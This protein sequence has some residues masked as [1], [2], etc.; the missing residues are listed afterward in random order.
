MNIFKHRPHYRTQKKPQKIQGNLN[1]IKNLLGPQRTET[2]NQPQGKNS[3]A[4]KL[5]EI[6]YHANEE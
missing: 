6:E 4:L 5:M 3:K 1:H 2:R